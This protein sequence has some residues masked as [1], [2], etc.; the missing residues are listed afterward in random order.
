MTTKRYIRYFLL[1]RIIIL[2][3]RKMYS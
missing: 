1:S 2:S 3:Q